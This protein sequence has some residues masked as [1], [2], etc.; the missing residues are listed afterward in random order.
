VYGFTAEVQS[1][2]PS[3][4]HL[5]TH[6]FHQL[7]L[8]AVLRPAPAPAPPTTPPTAP[9]SAPAASDGPATPPDDRGVLVLHGGLFSNERVNLDELRRIHRTREPP[10]QGPMAELLWSDPMV[11]PGRAPNPRGIAL[12]FGPGAPPHAPASR[13][14]HP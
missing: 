9:P 14:P 11:M 7:P 12:L 1:K 5:F 10:E 2:Y 6:L 13:T 8:A 4:H 3:M